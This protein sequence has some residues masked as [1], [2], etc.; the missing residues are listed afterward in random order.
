MDW[1]FYVSQ[2]IESSS[3]FL[4]VV[5]EAHNTYCIITVNNDEPMYEWSDETITRGNNAEFKFM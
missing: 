4:I 5:L 1:T 2:S 3:S